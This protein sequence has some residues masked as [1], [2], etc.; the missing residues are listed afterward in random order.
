MV[1]GDVNYAAF[2]LVNFALDEIVIIRSVSM[3]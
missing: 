2:N 3:Y 1:T